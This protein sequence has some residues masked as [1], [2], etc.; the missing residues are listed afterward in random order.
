MAKKRVRYKVREH[1]LYNVT[2]SV[3]KAL[4][5][6]NEIDPI[7]PFRA[8]KID[9]M[10]RLLSPARL[11]QKWIFGR[12]VRNTS[13][14]DH[15]PVFILGLWRSGTTHLHYMMARDS[16][17]GYLKN[18]Q[19]FTFN[20]SLL[21]LD[22][23][24]KILSIFV[25]GKRPQDNVRVTLDDPA[26]EEQAFSTM[27]TH[28]SIHSFFFPKNQTYFT[29]FHLFEEISP[30]EKLQWKEDY[31][32]LLKNI[33]YYSRKQK[34]LL[35]NP[36]NTGRVIGSLIVT[37]ESKATQSGVV[38]TS[39]TELATEVYS[40]EVIQV[41]KWIAR[42]KPESRARPSSRR[43]RRA[44]SARWRI[45]TIGSSNR[46]AR[47]RRQAAITIEGTASA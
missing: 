11:A 39:T 38:D 34:L 36:H 13:L 27:T 31:L 7:Y 44:N 16:Q 19:A 35:K 24:N 37:G 23:L 2:S 4:K 32:F 28:S 6:E 3:W 46:E 25:P 18:H 30:E 1:Q 9:W 21:S 14:E 8:R 33:S 40:S 22:R 26:E 10:S 47:L 41:A 20:M 29:K 42:K 15:P 5:R 17:F 45:S 12:R 43:F